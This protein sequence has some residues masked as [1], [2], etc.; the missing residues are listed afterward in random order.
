M[1]IV[2][3]YDV[4]EGKRKIDIRETQQQTHIHIHFEFSIKILVDWGEFVFYLK[5]QTS[6]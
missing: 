2:H 6:Q 1:Y 3:V 4:V 5:S